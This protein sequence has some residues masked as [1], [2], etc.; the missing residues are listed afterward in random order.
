MACRRENHERP[1]HGI[2]LLIF[3]MKEKQKKGL[4]LKYIE[5]FS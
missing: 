1:K 2:R 3:L 5:N 4:S